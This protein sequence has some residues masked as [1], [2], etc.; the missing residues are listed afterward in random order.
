MSRITGIDDGNEET[1]LDFTVKRGMD[2]GLMTNAD[3]GYGTHERYSGRLFGMYRD[4]KFRI[5]GMGNANNTGDR[6]FGGRGGGG[7]GGQ[8]LNSSKM[9]GVN[10]N[11]DNDTIEIGGMRRCD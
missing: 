5:Q 7:R 4:S 2:K 8:G 6:G 11:F 1:V 3:L 9:A 10:F